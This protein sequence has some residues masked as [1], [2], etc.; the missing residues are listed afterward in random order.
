MEN[1]SGLLADVAITDSTLFEPKAAAPMVD[2]RR[3]ARAVS[4]PVKRTLQ[5]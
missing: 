1:R 5:K 4:F 3:L 2:R